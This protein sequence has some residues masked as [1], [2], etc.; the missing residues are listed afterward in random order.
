MDH[1]DLT[2]SD[3]QT[4]DLKCLWATIEIDGH[5]YKQIDNAILRLFF[6]I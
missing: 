4:Q 1:T 3:D 6:Q 2:C 5:D